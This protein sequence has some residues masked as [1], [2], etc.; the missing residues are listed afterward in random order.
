[1]KKTLL[2]AAL[3]VG[4][5]GVA[6]AETSVTLYGIIDTGI[7]YNKVES[8]DGAKI[9]TQRPAGATNVDSKKLG[10]VN[11]V[12]SGSRWGLKGAEDLR[13]GLRAV[14]QLDSGYDSSPGHSAH[15]G[16]LFARQA[17]IAMQRASCDLTACVLHTHTATKSFGNE[18][19]EASL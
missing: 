2:A 13:D 7:C 19:R 9:G 1:M 14:F 17:T 8:Y 5:F 11:G 12:Q 16:R 6:Q 4:F 18:L 10:L 15:G 3:T